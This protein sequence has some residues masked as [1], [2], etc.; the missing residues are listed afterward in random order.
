MDWLAS[1]RARK[2]PVNPAAR[3]LGLG[4]FLRRYDS[5][6]RERLFSRQPIHLHFF[7]S[8]FCSVIF[9]NSSPTFLETMPEKHTDFQQCTGISRGFVLWQNKRGMNEIQISAKLCRIQKIHPK[10]KVTLGNGTKGVNNCKLR[11]WSGVKPCQSCQSSKMLQ[12]VIACNCK[13]R[14]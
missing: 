4:C 5:T 14:L 2:P 1:D 9:L 10:L 7:L 13:S 11:A 6:E 3:N 8:L 12:K